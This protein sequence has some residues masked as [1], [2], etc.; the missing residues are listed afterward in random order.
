MNQQCAKANASAALSNALGS[1]AVSTG[2]AG[3]RMMR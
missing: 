2:Y 3:A 1:L